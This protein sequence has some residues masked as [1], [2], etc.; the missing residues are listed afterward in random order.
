MPNFVQARSGNG[1]AQVNEEASFLLCCEG[2]R[3]FLYPQLAT[4]I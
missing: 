4:V 2:T 1:T 3:H